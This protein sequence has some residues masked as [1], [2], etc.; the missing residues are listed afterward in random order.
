MTLVRAISA[1][2][3]AARTQV[4]V[5]ANAALT[6]LYWQIGQRVRTDVLEEGRAEYGAQIVSA[7]G[8]SA[9]PKRPTRSKE[10]NK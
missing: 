1:M 9:K 10:C 4:S 2:V 7:A 6:G 8:A 5:A 3:D